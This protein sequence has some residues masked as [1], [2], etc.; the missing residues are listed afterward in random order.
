MATVGETEITLGHMIALRVTLPEQ[1]NQI[2]PTL[3]KG[4]LDQL[5]SKSFS[6][7]PTR[8]ICR[9]P[10]GYRLDNEERAI[11]ADEV[12]GSPSPTARHRRC[13][14]APYDSEYA[15]TGDETEYRASHILVETEDEAQEARRRDRRRGE[16]RGAGAGAFHRPLGPLGGRIG[17]VRR[18]RHGARILEDAVATLEPGEVSDPVQTQFGWHV[19][20]LNETRIKERPASTRCGTSSPKPCAGRR[21]T[22]MSR[23]SR[24]RAMWIA[25]AAMAWMRR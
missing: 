14:P 13:A 7:R 21:S 11:T 17:L 2:P 15:E 8:A 18:G 1:Y 25:P 12:I 20:K 4:V 24:P 22:R 3:F 6:A 19:I 9:R 5:I 23:S 16:F 10:P